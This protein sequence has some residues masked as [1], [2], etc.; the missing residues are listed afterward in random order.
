MNYHFIYILNSATIHSFHFIDKS[1]DHFFQELQLIFSIREEEMTKNQKGLQYFQ[2]QY[3]CTWTFKAYGYI[4]DWNVTG[5]SNR[6]IFR[7]F[8]G[9]FGLPSAWCLYII[10][11]ASAWHLVWVGTSASF[12]VTVNI[13]W[14]T[15]PI[16]FQLLPP[17]TSHNSLG[18]SNFLL[19]QI[20]LPWWDGGRVFMVCLMLFYNH[21]LS[22]LCTIWLS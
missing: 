2:N 7:H 16:N 13:S 19:R 14:G 8:I 1:I 20:L 12:S 18:T 6:Y 10:C 3:P 17:S 4:R 11:P 9:T 15:R 22:I 5:L 21:V